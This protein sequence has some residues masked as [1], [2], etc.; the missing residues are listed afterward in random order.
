VRA[1]LDLTVHEFNR[2]L[3][4]TEGCVGIWDEEKEECDKFDFLED[5]INED[6]ITVPSNAPSVGPTNAPSELPTFSPTLSQFPTD[7][8]STFPSDGPTKSHNPTSSSIPSNTP[9]QSSFP[10][11]YPSNKPTSSPS[12]IPSLTPT[13]SHTPTFK[14]TPKPFSYDFPSE[15][16]PVDPPSGYFNYDPA[17]DYGPDKWEDMSTDDIKNTPE[18]NYWKQFDYAIK[19]DLSQNFCGGNKDRQKDFEQS[20]I[21]I[22]D[23]NATC[24]E[25]HQIRDRPGDY[26]LTDDEITMQILH[27][28]LRI[29]FPKQEGEEPDSPKADIPKG[30]GDFLPVTH[31]DIILPG[32]HTINGTEYVGEYRIYHLHQSGKGVPVVTVMMD[33]NPA[34]KNNPHL[35]QALN[36]WKEIFNEHAEEC[37]DQRRLEQGLDPVPPGGIDF[38]SNTLS[39]DDEQ[40]EVKENDEPQPEISHQQNHDRHQLRRAK[41]VINTKDPSDPYTSFGRWDPYRMGSILNTYWFYGYEGSLTE[42]PCTQ[43][44]HYRIMDKPML[45]SKPQLKFM[46]KLIFLHEQ[47]QKDGTCVRT[48]NHFNGRVN[49][50]LQELKGRGIHQCTC[51]H[52][53]H[54]EYRYSGG[55]FVCTADQVSDPPMGKYTPSDSP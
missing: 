48:S 10:S 11:W 22:F 8:P 42:P 45:I 20:P 38:F 16:E 19:E 46:R 52:F 30:W 6:D 35:Q 36:Q 41:E 50:P 25:Y 51:E 26:L 15:P 3:N 31:V 49:R 14:P 33:L 17:S 12:S 28:K 54:D 1:E 53:T 2:G 43:F 55:P 13:K 7:S 24:R 37:E 5:V 23:T 47:K 39:F 21:D 34:N 29:I 4:N 18:Y 40:E 27:N 9:S 44:A 32:E